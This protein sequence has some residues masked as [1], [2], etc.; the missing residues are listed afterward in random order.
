MQVCAQLLIYEQQRLVIQL[1]DPKPCSVAHMYSW[2][3]WSMDGK[4]GSTS[5]HPCTTIANCPRIKK[6]LYHEE[7]Q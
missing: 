6:Q 1:I 4:Y 5:C 2:G 7:V 3:V